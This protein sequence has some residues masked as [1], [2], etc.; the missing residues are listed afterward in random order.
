MPGVYKGG[1]FELVQAELIKSTGTVIGLTAG[2]LIGLSIFE[3]IE[4]YSI[5][6]TIIIQDAIN[7]ASFGPIIGQEYLKLKIRTPTITGAENIIDFSENALMITSLDTREDS[8]SGVQASTLSF[9]SREFVANQRARVRRSLRGSYS[10]IVRE[11]LRVDLGSK[12]KFNFEPSAESKKII[13]PNITPYDVISIAG[14]S[15]VSKKHSDPTYLFFETCHGFNFKTLGHLYS[16]K[17]KL[18][19]S[20]SLAGTKYRPDGAV[21]ILKNISNIESYQ[22]TATPDTVYNY[23]AGVYSSELIVHDIISKSYQKNTYDYIRDF[24]NE[25]HI[26]ATSTGGLKK[27]YPLVNTLALSPDGKNISSFPSRQCLQPTVG[28]GIDESYE[29]YYNKYSFSSNTPHR[30]ILQRNAQFGML[31]TGLQVNIDVLG[32]T[33]LG[34]GDIVEC[35][36][37]YTATFQTAKKEE[38][39]RLY[40]GHFLIKKLRHDFICTSGSLSGEHTISMNLY[41]DDLL[42]PLSVPSDNYEPTSDKS[43]GDE[44]EIWG[45]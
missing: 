5:T 34:A 29:D 36:I 9:V 37:P 6:G 31:E 23:T 33:L 13:A 3:D 4:Q 42:N 22:I 7:L 45:D 41:K 16:G 20:Q 12:K 26:E 1:E 18:K 21:D 35:N 28:Y 19:Y 32:N 44:E 43:K 2:K 25:R 10:D 27:S 24:N 17:P 11:M 40:R 14:K 8:G 39:D 38:F 30:T 15:A